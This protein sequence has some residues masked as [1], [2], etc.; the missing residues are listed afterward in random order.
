MIFR[1]AK[2]LL[3]AF[4]CL[5]VGLL[6]YVN[7]RTETFFMR[8]MEDW[9]IIDYFKFSNNEFWHNLPPLIKYQIPDMLWMLSMIVVIRVIWDYRYDFIS[10]SFLLAAFVMGIVFEALQSVGITPGTFDYLDI[11]FT[12]IGGFVALYVTRDKRVRLN[13]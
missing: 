3:I 8:F 5:L 11:T 1:K 2:D 6:I 4:L 10:S 7:S 9:G 13:V 12:L